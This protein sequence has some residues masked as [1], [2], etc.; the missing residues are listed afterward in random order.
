MYEQLKFFCPY[1]PYP[2]A[3]DMSGPS[4]AVTW[5]GLLQQK[6]DEC[7]KLLV[8]SHKMLS[9]FGFWVAT[10]P[11]YQLHVENRKVVQS[12][13]PEPDILPWKKNLASI[14]LDPG[15]AT[16]FDEAEQFVGAV[17]GFLWTGG[18]ENDLHSVLFDCRLVALDLMEITRRRRE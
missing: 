14:L 18:L 11:F 2:S 12:A 10:K 6:P 17:D 4:E 9:T 13:S 7:A 5:A 15:Q 3:A 16:V 8:F 1:Y